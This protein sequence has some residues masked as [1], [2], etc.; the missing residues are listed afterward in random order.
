MSRSITIN[1]PETQCDALAEEAKAAGRT[2]F[3]HCRQ[4]LLHGTTTTEV[5]PTG[6]K[7]TRVNVDPKTIVDRHVLAEAPVK[8]P[9]RIGRLETM[10]MEMGRAI[11]NLANPVFAVPEGAAQEPLPDDALGDV[12]AESLRA[13]DTAGMTQIDREPAP[14]NGMVRPLGT[15]M[16]SRLAVGGVP[17]HLEGHFPA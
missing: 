4:K 10:M 1:L 15:R 14:N 6:H 17:S 8:E 16:R 11:Q 12:V 5:H 3:D 7:V 13:A 2:F 9:D